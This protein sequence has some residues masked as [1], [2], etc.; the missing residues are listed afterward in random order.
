MGGKKRRQKTLRKSA[1]QSHK[2]N[3]KGP[4][5]QIRGL[6]SSC[7]RRDIIVAKILSKTLNM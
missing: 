5:G 1:L 3:R 4:M 6:H 7:M 2:G